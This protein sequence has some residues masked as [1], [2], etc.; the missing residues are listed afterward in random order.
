MGYEF[1][2][3]QKQKKFAS[4]PKNIPTTTAKGDVTTIQTDAQ[5]VITGII[6]YH[7][8]RRI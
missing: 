7:F 5:N 8:N 4:K 2:E 6:P 3:T 1:R